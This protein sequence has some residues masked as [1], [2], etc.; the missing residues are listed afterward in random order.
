MG[1]GRRDVQTGMPWK[2]W[3]R[4]GLK[5]RVRVE[6][7]YRVADGEVDPVD[8]AGLVDGEV[9]GRAEEDV[10]EDAGVHGHQGPAA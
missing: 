7:T 6:E 4:S 8:R 3:L 2:P 10:E 1:W 5:F 9:V